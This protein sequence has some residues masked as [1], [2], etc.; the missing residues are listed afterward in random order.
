MSRS[1]WIAA[2]AVAV[3]LLV[4]LALEWWRSRREDERTR[5][6]AEQDRAYRQELTLVLERLAE[7]QQPKSTAPRDSG[8]PR[9]A[10]VRARITPRNA[11]GS[12]QLIFTNRG[13][14]AAT[15][16]AASVVPRDALIM[17][18]QLDPAPLLLPG[19]EFSGL[20]MAH[21]SSPPSVTVHLEWLDDGG[22]NA[23]DQVLAIP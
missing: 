5:K 18:V 20:V 14:G 3:A 23:D 4:P 2:S 9:R 22:P 13:P 8:G 6:A 12:R 15:L 17:R 11:K 16:R 19:E 7:L 21:G 1:D 10:I